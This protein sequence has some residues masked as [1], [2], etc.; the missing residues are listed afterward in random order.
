MSVASLVLVLGVREM[1]LDIAIQARLLDRVVHDASQ[2]LCDPTTAAV[3]FVIFGSGG[4]SLQN[5]TTI[6][7]T[8]ANNPSIITNAYLWSEAFIWRRRSYQLETIL[9]IAILHVL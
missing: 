3:I 6:V 8:G 5:D 4:S 2:A 1:R 9:S 7:A